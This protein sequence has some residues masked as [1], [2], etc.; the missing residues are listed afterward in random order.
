MNAFLHAV[1]LLGALS[2]IPAL[3]WWATSKAGGR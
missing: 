2:L 1:Y 3:F